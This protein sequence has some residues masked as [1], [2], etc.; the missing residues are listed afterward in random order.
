MLIQTRDL[1]ALHVADED[2]GDYGVREGGWYAADE[3]DHVVLGP[4]A[5]LAECEREIRDRTNPPG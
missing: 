3:C 2:V 4:F 1:F 5:S